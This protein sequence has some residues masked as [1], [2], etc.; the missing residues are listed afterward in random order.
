MTVITSPFYIKRKVGRKLKQ[1]IHG[2][3]RIALFSAR[4]FVFDG[5]A[6]FLGSGKC[7]AACGK[8]AET[9]SAGNYK[10]ADCVQKEVCAPNKGRG[11]AVA[12]V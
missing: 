3:A 4:G 7:T 6:V 8:G 10:R 9:Q 2:G 1:R 5:G 12:R 11:D